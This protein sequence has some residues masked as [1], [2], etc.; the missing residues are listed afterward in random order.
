[1]KMPKLKYVGFTERFSPEKLIEAYIDD[2]YASAVT[3]LSVKKLSSYLYN[4]T[5]D[6]YRS[7]GNPLIYIAFRDRGTILVPL[8]LNMLY[9]RYLRL[10]KVA[11]QGGLV[12]ERDKTPPEKDLELAFAKAYQRLTSPGRKRGTAVRE[13]RVRYKNVELR[14]KVP[15]YREI[16]KTKLILL[17]MTLMPVWVDD[18]ASAVENTL[19][20]NEFMKTTI[21]KFFS[22]DSIRRWLRNQLSY[23][24]YIGYVSEEK[25]GMFIFSR[26]IDEYR[27]I[28][29]HL[30][31]YIADKIPAMASAYMDFA[32]D[33]LYS[34]VSI[35]P[36]DYISLFKAS[37]PHLVKYK[38]SSPH[39]HTVM[40]TRSYVRF[41]AV[42]RVF[43]SKFEEYAPFR[44]P[45]DEMLR[46]NAA[47]WNLK[48]KFK[49]GYHGARPYSHS[50][51]AG[52][53]MCGRV[54]PVLRRLT[55]KLLRELI[56]AIRWNWARTKTV[57]RF[58]KDKGII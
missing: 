19:T 47:V 32:I 42:L 15:S 58:L 11:E 9:R 38:S 35:K 1:M 33:Y 10:V 5:I 30:T 36:I 51:Y 45:V 29:R 48:E 41:L 24:K 43:L 44:K 56:G 25:K 54:G 22:R 28:H 6:L 40:V 34:Y 2:S 57:C 3:A 53:K 50:I 4:A 52:I 21:E 18:L 13:Y 14:L 55:P 8:S 26:G 39:M 23:L 17:T 49:Y 31:S 12:Y 7:G 20:E 27:E 16:S 46:M 37:I